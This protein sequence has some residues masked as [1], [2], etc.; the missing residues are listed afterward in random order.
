MSEIVAI[1]QAR[2][3]STRLPHKVLLNLAGKPVLSQVFNQLSF[4]KSISEI[5]LAT[6]TDSSDDPLEIW[7]NENNKKFYRG[8][9]NNVL[10]RYFDTAKFFGAQNIVRITADCPLIDPEI[11]DSVVHKFLEGDYDYFSNTNP[12]TFPDGLDTEI[13]TF[14]SLELAFK[15][16]K[17]SSELE[18]VTSYFKNHPEKFK[19]GN[20]ISDVNYE[21]LRWTLD[22]KE[23]FEL[24]SSIYR[25]LYREN[26]FIRWRDIL[27]LVTKDKKLL[28]INSYIKRNDGLIK[29]LKE[30]EF[31]V[32]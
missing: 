22:Q 6:S 11:V 28:S 2:L 14:H 8:D 26:S 20:L 25:E 1:V 17:L 9:L 23:D 32:D 12:P 18:H 29:F 27:K 31:D 5:V 13:F 21:N 4:S 15:E 19:I 16:A 7:A 3:S 10:K 24:I 30:D